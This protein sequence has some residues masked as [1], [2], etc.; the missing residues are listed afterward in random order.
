MTQL[1]LISLGGF[2]GS[3]SRF[4]ISLQF[5][6]Q[7]IGTLIVNTVG[8]LA[9]VITFHLFNN[10]MISYLFWLFVG[11]GFCGSFTTFSTFSYEAIS[12]IL[13]KQYKLALFYISMSLFISF[14]LF[15]GLL[16]F[17]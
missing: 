6:L 15:I 4:L 8:S 7:F 14:S 1:L 12:L 16:Y 17:I 9:I 3:T 5:K 13:M 11:V 2:I 10:D